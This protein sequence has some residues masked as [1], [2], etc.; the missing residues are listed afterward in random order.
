MLDPAIRNHIDARRSEQLERL[1][2]LLSIPSVANVQASPDPCETCAAWL[3]DYLGNLGIEARVAPT[4]GKPAVLAATPH[5]ADKP[6]LLIY[7]HYD[8]QPPDPLEL[9]ASAPFTPEV[10]DGYIY[11][12]G[13]NDNKGQLFAH[14][15]AIEAYRATGTDLPVNLKLLIEGEEEI[16]SPNLEP[17]IESH[18]TELTAD[19]AV[20]SDSEFYA[21]GVPAITYSLRGLAYAEVTFTGPAADVHSG[22]HGGALTNPLNAL[23]AMLAALHDA[24]GRVTLPGFYDNVRAITDAEREQ[25]RLLPFDERQYAASLGVDALGGGETDYS[26]TERRW[27]RPTLDCNGIVGGY[28]GEGS[29]TII[30]SHAGAKIS[31]RLVSDQDPENVITALRRFV[32]DRTPPGIRSRLDVHATS[33]PVM[34]DTTSPA[35]RAGKAA[36][37]EAFGKEPAMIRCGASVPVTE[38]LQRMLGLDAVLMGFGLPDDN[39]HSPNERFKLDQLYR[40]AAAAAAFMQNLA[41]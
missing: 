23:A 9:W 22:L 37:A 16:G 28:A 39:L 36:L 33:R 34:L 1:L 40:G 14:L 32:S 3:A 12:R 2:E 21:D 31:M 41:G 20:I 11:A 10:R 24:K 25:W 7:G 30:P 38:L 29:K 4:A 6:T 15:L 27:A 17:F 26:V 19:T 8:V 18:R 5:K 35:M 13:A